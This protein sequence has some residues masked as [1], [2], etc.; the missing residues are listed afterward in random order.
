MDCSDTTCFEEAAK[1]L[2]S[3]FGHEEM[4]NAKVLVLANKRDLP[5]AV[6]A[7]EL[8]KKKTEPSLLEKVTSGTSK[9]APPQMEQVY[10]RVLIGYLQSCQARLDSQLFGCFEGQ[11]N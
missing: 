2:H 7:A 10:T 3:L 11:L 1:E 9:D 5:H 8:A 6:T 4:R